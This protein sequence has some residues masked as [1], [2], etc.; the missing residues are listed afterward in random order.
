MNTKTLRLMLLITGWGI[1]ISNAA[2]CQ[3]DCENFPTVSASYILPK[4]IAVGVDYFSEIGL[5]GGISIAYTAPKTTVIKQGANEYEVSSN[6]LDLITSVGYRVFRKEYVVS[7]FL[8]T[9]IIFGDKL[10]AQ[11]FVS[12]KIL[13]P[14]KNKAVS[15]EPIYIFGRGYQTKLSLHFII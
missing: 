3:V 6:S 14:I 2:N 9:G 13:F 7:G 1:L 11:P 10:G 15:V 12:S 8:N 4:T 5:T